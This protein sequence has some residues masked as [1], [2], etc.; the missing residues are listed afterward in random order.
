VRY[1]IAQTKGNW[2]LKDNKSSEETSGT[3]SG[4][5]LNTMMFAIRLKYFFK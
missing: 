2:S 4:I 1:C 5:K 3:F